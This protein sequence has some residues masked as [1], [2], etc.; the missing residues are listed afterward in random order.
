[1]LPATQ[2]RFLYKIV[3]LI[4]TSTWLILHIPHD[5]LWYDETVNAYLATQ[6]WSTIWQ[7][8]TQIDNQVP[9]HFVAL[10]LW[11]MGVGYSE[12]SLR[13][14]SMLCAMLASAGMI[15]LA[16]QLKQ[17]GLLATFFLSTSG[18]FLYAAGE[19]RVYALALALL[20][21]STVF[22]LQLAKHLPNIYYP[23]WLGY[24]LTA[25]PLLY[26]HYTA[27]LAIAAHGIFLGLRLIEQRGRG[28]YLVGAWGILMPLAYLPWW[29][30][31]R[32]RDFNAGTAFEGSVSINTA[33][34][35]YAAFYAFGQKIFTPSTEQT[36]V[37]VLAVAVVSGIGWGI[38]RWRMQQN[39]QI[40][41]EWSIPFFLTI[42]PLFGMTYAVYA[43]EAKLSG[44]HVWVMWVGVPLL[45]AGGIE[46]SL[47]LLPRQFR[48]PVLIPF[49]MLPLFL[50]QQSRA[51]TDQYVGN[52]REAFA[53][54]NREHNPHDLLILRDGTLFTT[55]EY[56]QS[57]IP[58]IG[59]PNDQL[60]DVQR[61]VQLHEAL[62]ILNPH[63]S[64]DIQYIWVL[65]WQGDTMDPT[66]LAYAIPEYLSD[67]Q[68]IVFL[69]PARSDHPTDVFLARYQIIPHRSLWEHVGAY[70]GIL[71]VQP[72]GP[73]L[74][75]TEVYQPPADHD[76]CS[77]ILHTWWWKG[78]QIYPFTMMSF[79]LL[80]DDN[81]RL[82]QI[83]LPPG[84]Y[85]YGQEKWGI[86]TLGRAELRFDC[87]LIDLSQ[88]YHAELVIYDS[89]GAK[90]P[91]TH[92]LGSVFVGKD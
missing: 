14:F 3:Y 85:T 46:A 7:W 84:G 89:S 59:I 31:L 51:L 11:G 43:I 82:A 23:A 71:K 17:Q 76:Q 58:Y 9:L 53:I 2:P 15:A 41:S 73:S 18:G 88:N 29:L 56:Y 78:E 16:Q 8:S 63:L 47:R 28:I 12:F 4:I 74:L 90:P 69:D 45:L 1:M 39:K 40:L 81:A 57:P 75:G 44:R 48:I 34:T 5:S 25:I 6:S 42:I 91:Q 38:A 86:F 60:T 70:T 62:D 67:G 54:I 52:F 32:G 79:R 24:I 61:Q 68:R 37:I 19:V 10:K 13:V 30:A 26:T 92:D 36:A 83:D 87:A 33:L 35:T 66:A 72:D 65:S 80:D 50:Y 55:A 22:L 49:L 77:L 21:W 64:S 27:W 20:I